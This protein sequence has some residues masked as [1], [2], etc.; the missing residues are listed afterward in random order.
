MNFY[1]TNSNKEIHQE[2]D[3]ILKLCMTSHMTTDVTHTF[4]CYAI[5]DVMGDITNVM[6]DIICR[7]LHHIY[8]HHYK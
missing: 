3:R 7:V 1:Y 8:F 6:C 4:I 5:E 2:S